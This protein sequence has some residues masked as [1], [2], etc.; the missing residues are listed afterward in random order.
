MKLR[1][2]KSD[3][4]SRS[5]STLSIHL[6]FIVIIFVLPEA[7]LKVAIPGRTLDI[8][9]PMYAKSL[10]TIGVF[11]LNFFLVIPHTL[12]G[13]T[14]NRWRFLTWNVLIVFGGAFLIWL[15]YRV[16]YTGP[17]IHVVSPLASL[18]YF[19][20]DAAILI[21]A[22][23][24]AVAVQI[25]RRWLELERRDEHLSAVRRQAELDSLRSQLNP[26]FLFNTLN[27]IYALIDISPA[28][29]QKSIHELSALL[30]YVVYDNPRKVPL[31]KEID[32]VQN[33]VELMR[34]R[35]GN[36]PVR[37]TVERIGDSGREIAPLLFVNLVENAFKHGNT[38]DPS[39]S[40]EIIIRSDAEKVNCTTIN[41]SDHIEKKEGGVGLPNLRR[42]LEL[43]YGADADLTTTISPEGI[44]TASLTVKDSSQPP[45]NKR[46]AT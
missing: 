17:R 31:D 37:L 46:K 10:I 28:Q 7:L 44:F 42:R 9:W 43:L 5:L 26:H 15:V 40:I 14:R 22:V 11:Y 25:S 8:T 29:A 39:Q 41:H 36:R 3:F 2:R 1:L 33:Y 32:F 45:L 6:L 24:L 23:S 16:I 18:S 38:A 19:V 12:N 4:D 27:S 21:L 13:P 34:L 30:R 20:R 35:M